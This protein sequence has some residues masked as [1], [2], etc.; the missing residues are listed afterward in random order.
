MVFS[1][2]LYKADPIFLNKKHLMLNNTLFFIT[3]CLITPLPTQCADP[4][5]E[6]PKVIVDAVESPG[7]SLADGACGTWRWIRS[8]RL[9]ATVN[10]AA[11]QTA[12]QIKQAATYLASSA[13][14]RNLVR[15]RQQAIEARKN[16][17]RILTSATEC[18]QEVSN[19]PGTLGEI[20]KTINPHEV[21]FSDARG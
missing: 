17:Y 11:T 4:N 18:W 19:A 8:T 7:Q 2:H 15:E 13:E 21:Q 1:D 9:V 6:L 10:S 16:E 14:E 5:I 20:T 12:A 3:L